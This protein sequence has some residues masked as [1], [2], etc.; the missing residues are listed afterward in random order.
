MIAVGLQ[1]VDK[2]KD[3]W[4]D[5]L[6]ECLESKGYYCTEGT[7]IAD[8]AGM[9]CAVFVHR[10]HEAVSSQAICSCASD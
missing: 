4:K 10:D 5:K 8:E 2:W 1:Q 7:M 9:L 3:K 6:R